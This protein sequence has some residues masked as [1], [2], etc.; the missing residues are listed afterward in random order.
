M[1]V[2]GCMFLSYDCSVCFS[3]AWLG[4][5]YVDVRF[6]WM[7]H[8]HIITPPQI[9]SIYDSTILL[10]LHTSLHTTSTQLHSFS[11][12]LTHSL[13]SAIEE[14]YSVTLLFFFL[15]NWDNLRRQSHP[16]FH[17]FSSSASPNFNL[18]VLV[19]VFHTAQL[20]GS[21]ATARQALAAGPSGVR[22][23]GG[24][25]CKNLV[26]PKVT[27]G[28]TKWGQGV[29]FGYTHMS[30]LP[31]FSFFQCM[32]AKGLQRGCTYMYTSHMVFFF[33]KNWFLPKLQGVQSVH[34]VFF[35]FF[36]CEKKRIN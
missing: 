5:E 14:Q 6:E 21:G 1:F 35:S 19:I 13:W 10:H 12:S 36:L 8:F 32:E 22:G 9:T 15:C 31:T 2:V 29:K 26:W 23:A 27:L 7:Y 17:P 30:T 24:C 4:C 25:K 33:Q 11:T 34:P 3:V 18:Q 20:S 28:H 16:H